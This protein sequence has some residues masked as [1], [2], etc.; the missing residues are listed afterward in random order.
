MKRIVLI[1]V[2]AISG[3]GIIAYPFIGNYLNQKNATQV[4]ESYQQ[5]VDKL[6]PEQVADIFQQAQ[7]YNENLLGQP[8]HDPFLPGSGIVMPD[9]YYQV[10]NVKETMGQLEIPSI[11]VNLPIY[12]GTKDTILRKAVGHLEGSALPIG[13]EG[14]HTVLTSHTGLTNAKLFTDLTELKKGDHFYIHVL[15]RKLAYEVDKIS[16]IEPDH[17]EPLKA[18]KGK[19]YAT[20]LT[21]TPYGVNSHRLLVRGK[22]V[23]YQPHKTTKK[24]KM[25]QENY[26]LLKAVLITS[27]V[28]LVLILLNH[29]RNKRKAVR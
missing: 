29:F 9:N 2:L 25:T 6:T 23:P 28:M 14:S 17:T 11:D 15:D 21:C 10:L 3:L 1:V 26:L 19:D 8:A 13:G 22:R 18:V 7:I 4:M 12:H 16:V 27:G 5:E 20:L 24:K